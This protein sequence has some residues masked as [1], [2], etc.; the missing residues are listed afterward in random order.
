MR[1]TCRAALA[2]VSEGVTNRSIAMRTPLQLLQSLNLGNSVAEFDDGL[3]RYFLKTNIFVRFA[4]DGFDI[5]KGEKGSGKSAI[6]R[7]M[8]NRDLTLDAADL[9]VVPG[10]NEVGAPVFR[11]ISELT[12]ADEARLRSMW[13]LYLLAVAANHLKKKFPSDADENLARVV[14]DLVANGL[15]EPDGAIPTIWAKVKEVLSH[16]SFSYKKNG[17]EVKLDFSKLDSELTNFE[18]RIESLLEKL[19]LYL[20]AK[21]LRLW[22]LFDRLDESF[23]SSPAME[24]PVLRALCRTYLDL[25]SLSHMKVKLF[26]RQDLFRRIASGGFVN[27]SHLEAKSV[28]LSWSSED[29]HALLCARIRGNEGL[30]RELGVDNRTSNTSLFDKFFP[31]QVEVGERKPTTWKWLLTRIE[32]SNGVRA[33][34]N[35]IDLINLAKDAQ[36][37]KEERSVKQQPRRNALIESDSIKA[38][39]KELS[40]KRVNDTLIAEAGE[41]AEH[42]QQFK[43]G[44]AVQTKETISTL[45]RKKG[46]ELDKIIDDLKKAGFL[47]EVGGALKIPPWYR[48]GLGI[49]QGRA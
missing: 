16:A 38:A 46:T 37:K 35:L 23:V 14:A 22:V 30:M 39:L 4:E 29:L 13:K 21:N 28:K 20:R 10:F 3:N 40:E 45:L 48:A 2:T 41:L 47:G 5:V 34:R 31:E 17:T 19:D 1:Q 43:S 12:T 9:E 42:I 27:L 18:G 25:Q 32:D 24:I 6:Y 8:K 26:F 11:K 7:A 49:T 44:K 33:P 15:L 36:I